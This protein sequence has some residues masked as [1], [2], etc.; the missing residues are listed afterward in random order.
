M[1]RG[2]RALNVVVT[3]WQEWLTVGRLVAAAA[4]VS[5]SE[6]RNE[7]K[8]TLFA[9][10]GGYPKEGPACPQPTGGVGWGCGAGSLWREEFGFTNVLPN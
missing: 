5:F 8:S 7:E 1:W 3:K 4:K 10:A 2:G 6:R 9:K